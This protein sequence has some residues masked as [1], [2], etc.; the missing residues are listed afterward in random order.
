VLAVT[1]RRGVERR[2]DP[3]VA[4]YIAALG[5][6]T[7]GVVLGVTMALDAPTMGRR[8]AHV[9]L[10][11][12]GLIGLVIGGTLPFFAATVGRSRMAPYATA[13]RLFGA[14]AWQTAA[15]ATAVLG[16][17][18]GA[19]G[20]AAG[21]F[22]AYAAGI[23]AALWLLPR[24]TRRQLRWA[25]PRLVAL[26]AG[27][28]WWAVVVAATAVE[29]AGGDGAVLGG[30]WLLVLVVGGYAQILWGSL[31]YL[32]P[33]LRGGGHEQ[34]GRGFATTRSWAALVAANLAALALALDVP[35]VAAA[36][37]GVWVLDTAARA[38]RVGLGGRTM[39]A[40]G[41]PA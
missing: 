5:A 33:M 40:K 7:A 38:W 13:A 9:T 27:G 39:A 29:A 1:A 8:A 17:A 22:G 24:P 4:A 2:F 34:L 3:A 41:E 15:L 21:G 26:W 36:G 10:N 12:L 37:I 19:G 20:V 14:V 28:L 16:L 11:V 31:A 25:G 18:T 35:E 23:G 32:L 30:R 6:G